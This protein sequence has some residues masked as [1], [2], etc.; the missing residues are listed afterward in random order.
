MK[1]LL[2]AVYLAHGGTTPRVETRPYDV[3]KDCQEMASRYV[4]QVISGQARAFCLPY[5]PNNKHF[6]AFV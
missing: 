5:R 6:R 4:G 2:I 1:F 3:K